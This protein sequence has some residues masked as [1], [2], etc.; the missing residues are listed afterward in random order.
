MSPSMLKTASATTSLPALSGARC[1]MR[2]RSAMSLCL[3][4]LNS[5]RASMQPSTM[6]AW[7]HLSESTQSPRPTRVLMVARLV[8]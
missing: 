3:K 7:F 2:S 1:N 8:T 6:L 4:R 5:P